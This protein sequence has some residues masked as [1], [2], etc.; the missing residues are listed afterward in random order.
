MLDSHREAYLSKV[1][2]E[3]MYFVCNFVYLCTAFLLKLT[4]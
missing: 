2:G 1:C 4:L 3:I